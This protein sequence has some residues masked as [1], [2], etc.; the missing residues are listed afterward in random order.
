MPDLL[1]MFLS[2]VSSPHDPY[3]GLAFPVQKIK[4]SKQ[5]VHLGLAAYTWFGEHIYRNSDLMVRVS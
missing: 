3:A 4:A 2:A 1:K 5:A